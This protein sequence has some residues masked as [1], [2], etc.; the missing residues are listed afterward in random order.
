MQSRFKVLKHSSDQVDLDEK[1]PI[2]ELAISINQELQLYL[3]EF[4]TVILGKMHL[5]TLGAKILYTPMADLLEQFANTYKSLSPDM[6][7]VFD[8]YHNVRALQKTCEAIDFR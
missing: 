2:A 4:D 6:P 7:F 5:P 1:L 8:L 3:R